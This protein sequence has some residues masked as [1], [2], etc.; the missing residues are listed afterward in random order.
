MKF[1]YQLTLLTGDVKY[2]DAFETSLYNAYLGSINTA[3]VTEPTIREIFPDAFY[4]PL[5]FDSYSPLTSSRR[6]KKVGGYQMFPDATFYGCCAAIGAAGVG[7]ILGN[8]LLRNETGLYL[9]FYSDASIVTQTP[10]QKP[11]V[12]KVDTA[13]PFGDT[14]RIVLEMETPERF[15]MAFRIPAWADGARMTVNDIP[16]AVSHGYTEVLREWKPQDVIELRFPKAVKRVLP[17]AGA[18]NEGYFAAYRCG[19][20]VLAA[21]RRMT[22]PDAILPILCD[23]MGMVDAVADFCPSEIPDC[24]ECWTVRCENGETVRLIDY[25]SA[26]KTWKEDSKCAVWLLQKALPID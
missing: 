12:L 9:N 20:I 1:F 23:E 17:P 8:I 22:D 14:V 3:Q 25:A 13:Y 15:Q 5:P 24:M 16:F 11:M 4:E 6:G 10:T 18:E 21:D 19:A 2:V 26:G 7:S